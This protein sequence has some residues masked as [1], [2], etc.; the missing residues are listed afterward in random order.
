[1]NQFKILA[2]GV[3]F[4][5]DAFLSGTSLN[6]TNIWHKVLD[7][8]GHR[9]PTTSGFD[10]VF[11]DGASLDV[12]TQQ[13]IAIAYIND[14]LDALRACADFPGMQHYMLFIQQRVEITLDVCGFITELSRSLLEC[15]LSAKMAALTY[16]DLVRLDRHECGWPIET[17]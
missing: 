5:V 17:G 16:V 3:D 11:G 1:M 15:T 10:I 12:Y 6:P 2:H 9:N 8:R 14:N 13:Q 7:S 4:N